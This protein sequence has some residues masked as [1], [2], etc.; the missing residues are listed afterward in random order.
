MTTTPL[1][2]LGIMFLNAPE[3]KQNPFNTNS[4]YIYIISILPEFHHQ[5]NILKVRNMHF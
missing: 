1:S 2:T 4:M 5:K 3:I